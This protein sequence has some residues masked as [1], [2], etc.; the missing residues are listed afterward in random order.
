MIQIETPEKDTTPAAPVDASYESASVPE[1]AT[2]ATPAHEEA[3]RVSGQPDDVDYSQAGDAEP[4]DDNAPDADEPG[5]DA[6]PEELDELSQDQPDQQD[7][8]DQPDQPNQEG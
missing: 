1:S 5:D 3:D 8:V 6:V 4:D 7:E 2:P